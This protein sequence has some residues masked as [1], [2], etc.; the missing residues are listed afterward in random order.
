MSRENGPEPLLSVRD[1]AVTFEV[2]NGTVHAVNGLDLDVGAGEVLG[3]VGESGC[4][5][6]VSALALL[7]LL[8]R[9]GRVV[10]GTALFKGRDLLRLSQ[11]ELR[12]IRGREI[13]MVFQ[14]PLTSL[15]P[16]MRV[17]AQVAE[18]LEVHDP[19]LTRRT[20]ALRAVELLDLVG[21]PK[22]ALR[23]RDYPHLWSGGMRQRAMIA[24]AVANRPALM[25]ADEPTTALDVTV[26]A[27]ILEVLGD[28][29]RES[30]AA[31]ILITHDLGVVAEVCD[32]VVVVYGGRAVETAPVHDL[33]R[34]PRHPYTAGLLA[35]VPRIDA[36]VR[37]HDAIP[38]HPPT[39]LEPPTGCV[40]TDRCSLRAGRAL[41]LTESP[42]LRSVDQ[43]GHRAACHFAEEQAKQA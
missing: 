38:G 19:S 5:K 12:R 7:G 13:S 9:S 21:I 11:R 27:Q 31:V 35:T 23:A 40:F 30:G 2:P 24:M 26:Q 34:H 42:D 6:S 22:A 28:I 1:L 39:L 29:R 10:G 36:V 33:F 41:C 37:L 8:P 20:A 16:G 18:A 4:G 25:I 43:P 17:G 15:H 3:V 14:D 32:R